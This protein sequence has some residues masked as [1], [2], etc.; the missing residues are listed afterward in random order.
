MSNAGTTIN[1]LSSSITEVCSNT[2]QASNISDHLME[3]VDESKTLMMNLD[4]NAQAVG[5]VID[6]INGIAKMTDL[7]A[8][9]AKIEAVN[10]GEAGKSFVVVAN[11]VKDLSKKTAVATREVE[12]MIKGMQASASLSINSI[13]DIASTLNELKTINNNI[14]AS[15]EEQDAA[16]Q[17][18]ASSALDVVE[19]MDI[20]KKK[21]K[22]IAD[23]S[24]GVASNTKELSIKVLGISKKGIETVNKTED[25]LSFIK[26]MVKSAKNNMV[27]AKKVHSNAGKLDGLAEKLKTLVGQ[28]TS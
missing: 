7:L 24:T 9:N 11:E 19:S 26:N 10:A 17:E 16:S 25:L 20:L 14:A 13:N 3:K 22:K 27:D 2:L 1:Q 28:F 18:V 5:K 12:K 8:L 6:V 4:K 15:M 21:V 23:G